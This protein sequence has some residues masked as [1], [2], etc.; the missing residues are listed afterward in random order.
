MR[1]LAK[2]ASEED[3]SLFGDDLDRRIITVQATEEK[4]SETHP[5]T[6]DKTYW[7]LSTQ[8]IL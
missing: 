3:V 1:Q 2:D 4:N 8:P 6:R 7:V 5:D